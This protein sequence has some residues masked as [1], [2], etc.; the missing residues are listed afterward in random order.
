ML[1]PETRLVTH[2]LQFLRMNRPYV[3]IVVIALLVT[4]GAGALVSLLLSVRN[5]QGQIPQAL[6]PHIAW[7]FDHGGTYPDGSPLSYVTVSIGN[8]TIVLGLFDGLCSTNDHL[9]LLTNELSAARCTI[10]ETRKEIGIF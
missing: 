7:K 9:G 8:R 3:R 2:M 10:T 4:S 5:S 6:L 1:T